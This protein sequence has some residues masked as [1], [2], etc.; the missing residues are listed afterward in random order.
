PPAGST[1]AT[2]LPSSPPSVRLINAVTGA[3]SSQITALE[4]PL[5]QVSG[6]GRATINGRTMAVDS[7]GSTAYVITASGLSIL[8]L[9]PASA[10]ARPQINQNGA[11]NLASL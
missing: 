4:G 7:T 1:G 9:V 6:T 2:A 5:T 8:T 3:A 11:V 10:A